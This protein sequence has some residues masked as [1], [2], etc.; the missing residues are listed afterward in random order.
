MSYIEW[1]SNLNTNITLI[2]SQHQ[3]LVG[4]INTLHEAMNHGKGKEAL[5]SIFAELESYA[6]VHFTDEEKLLAK[7]EYPELD[8]Q[9]TQHQ[10]FI[11]QLGRHREDFANGKMLVSIEVLNFLRDW[12]INHIAHLDMKYVPYLKS[13]GLSS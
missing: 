6:E 1:Q 5:D 12:L 3:K 10:G 8:A 11:D 2:D 4:I 13:K 9:K 7:Y